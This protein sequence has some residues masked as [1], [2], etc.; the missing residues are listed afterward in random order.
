MNEEEPLTDEQQK[1]IAS[2]GMKDGSGRR[3]FRHS[4]LLI[5]AIVLPLVAAAVLMLVLFIPMMICSGSST[6]AVIACVVPCLLR[7]VHSGA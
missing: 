4:P 3:S 1:A 2:L 5:F 7:S 6:A